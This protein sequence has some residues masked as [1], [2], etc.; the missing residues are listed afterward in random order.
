MRPIAFYEIVEGVLYLTHERDGDDHIVTL[1]GD[2][3]CKILYE[4]ED[5]VAAKAVY[6]KERERYKKQKAEVAQ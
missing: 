3:N 6:D 1:Q 4:G 2:M 5:A